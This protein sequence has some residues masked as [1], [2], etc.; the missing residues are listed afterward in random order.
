ML[1]SATIA[2]DLSSTSIG[3]LGNGSGS[4]TEQRKANVR[5]PE[6]L[7]LKQLLLR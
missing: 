2:I 3:A 7:T 5:S 1:G 6:A 4:D